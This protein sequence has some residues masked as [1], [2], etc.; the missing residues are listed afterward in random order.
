MR[1]R[2]RRRLN[3]SRVV[4]GAGIPDQ[5]TD[6]TP[7]R[8]TQIAPTLLALLGLNPQSLNAV[9]VDDVKVLPVH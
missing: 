1:R 8:T 9:R 2:P 4:S 7:V 5:V 6:S 3:V